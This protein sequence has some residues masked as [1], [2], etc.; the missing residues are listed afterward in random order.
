MI[1]MYDKDAYVIAG[2]EGNAVE[3]YWQCIVFTEL[4][5]LNKVL[6]ILV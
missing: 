2:M 6:M 5:I 1:S 4:C 3:R